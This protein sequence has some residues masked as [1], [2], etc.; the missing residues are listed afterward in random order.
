M[1]KRQQDFEAIEV[2]KIV[3]ELAALLYLW[4]LG[5]E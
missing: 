1:I 3:K 4:S 2:V 5:D